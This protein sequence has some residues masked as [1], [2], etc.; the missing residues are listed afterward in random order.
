MKPESVHDAID[1]L[2]AADLD[3]ADRDEIA[4]LVRASRLLRS[5]LDAVDVRCARRGRELAAAGQA[6]PPDTL[7]GD[8]GQRSSKDAVVV[9]ARSQACD[10][11]PGFEAALTAGDISGG[12]VDAIVNVLRNLLGDVRAEFIA[13]EDLLLQAARRQRIEQ[14]QRSCRDLARD[15]AARHDATCETDEFERQRANSRIKRWVDRTTGMHHTHLELDPERD[16]R[17]QSAFDAHLRRARQ[18]DGN[19]G[20]PWHQLEV[21]AFLA[22]IEAGVIRRPPAGSGAGDV[23]ES[24]VEPSAERR[25]PD[26]LVLIDETTLRDRAHANGICETSNGIPLPVATVRRLCCDAEIIPMV[27]DGRGEVVDQGRSA[28][29]VT[30]AQR[31][32]LRAM[33]RTCVGHGCE[34][35]FEQ[36]HIHHVEFWRHDGPTDIDNLAPLCSRH[37]HLAHE[38]GWTLTMTPDRMITWTRPDGITHWTGSSIDRA[39][40][41]VRQPNGQ[42]A[43]KRATSPLFEMA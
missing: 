27:L 9:T 40:N 34:V 3:T 4:R 29:S 43:T 22:G 2:C 17:F 18:A 11:L 36:C 13:A 15:I 1:A 42:D 10:E 37:H 7:L 26:V 12:H 14:F 21:D 23:V 16:A 35:H 20:T 24:V 38:G 41:G 19:A 6:E 31:R 25:V 28:R 39:P 32:R 30:R 33:H 5:W 8:D